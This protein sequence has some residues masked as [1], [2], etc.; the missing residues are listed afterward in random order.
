MVDS[1]VSWTDGSLIADN[2]WEL[3]K[4]HIPEHMRKPLAR[5]LMNLFNEYGASDWKHLEIYE[6]AAIPKPVEA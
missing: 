1:K 3:F 4:R 2:V 6:A 5:R